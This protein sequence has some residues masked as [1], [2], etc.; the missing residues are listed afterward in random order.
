MHQLE[1]LCRSTT[2]EKLFELTL[3][4]QP[5]R[6]LLSI[7]HS[8]ELVPDIFHPWLIPDPW[9]WHQDVDFRVHQLIDH[10][11]LIDHGIVILKANIHRI[12][13]DLNRPPHVAILNWKTNS[14]GALLVKTPPPPEKTLPLVQTY[15]QPYF[16]I[17][18]S[19]LGHTASMIDL[20]SMP[21]HPTDYHLR[22]NPHQKPERPDFCLS[23]LRGEKS[24]SKSYIQSM[25]DKLET[26]SYQVLIND[27]YT[28]GYITDFAKPFT[29]NNIQIE[30]KRSLY[31][32]EKKRC[33]KPSATQ[34]KKELT[35]SL[36]AQFTT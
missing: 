25:K 20:H 29:K 32:D 15:H 33:L 9:S 3:P 6:G 24:C 17:I 34:L 22:K 28:G 12:A 11:T 16:T 23:H 35:Q 13:C 30:I 1:A 36:M 7:P 5:W 14:R 27:P 31:M 8:G 19:I 10:R 2:G 26:H 21:S 18:R 4:D